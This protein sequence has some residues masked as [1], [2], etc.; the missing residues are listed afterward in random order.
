MNALNPSLHARAASP[1]PAL[2]R[3]PAV[4]LAAALVF[5]AA[6][7][8]A[9]PVSANEG[10]SFL[11]ASL[12]I[13][14]VPGDKTANFAKLE[15]HARRAAAGGAR[16]IV[17]SECYLDGY[18]GHTKMHP[19]MT[20]EKLRE[21][22]EPVDGP[23]V[24]KAAALARELSVHLVFGF[25]EKRGD[26]VFNTAALIAPDGRILG[27]YSKSHTARPV[28]I[29]EPGSDFPVFDTAVGRIGLLICFDRQLPETS[30]LLALKGAEMI[31]IPAHSP[32]VDLINEDVMMRVRAYENNVYIVLANPFNTLV[33]DPGGDFIAHNAVRDDEGIVYA[34][35]DLGKREPDRGALVQRRPEIYGGLVKPR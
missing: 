15:T 28:E 23:Y 1:P 10:K 32:V 18:L 27:T 25:S 26:K 7:T 5:V 3:M 17:T 9:P 19:G 33:V 20:L 31:L 13:I 8:L 30:R 12:K 21:F 14:P 24:R 6:S 4:L 2:R 34:R 16:L 29:Y 11:A 35:I 22:A